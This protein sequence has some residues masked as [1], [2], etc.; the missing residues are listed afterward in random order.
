MSHVF[1]RFLSQFSTDF[2]EILQGLFSRHAATTVK[3]SLKNISKN[4][5]KLDHL[6]CSKFVITTSHYKPIKLVELKFVFSPELHYMP[7]CPTTT[8]QITR[9]ISSI[10]KLCRST[11]SDAGPTLFQPKP[12]KLSPT[13]IIVHTFFLNI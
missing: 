5:S 10:V 8:T 4:S 1:R 3:F 13:N 6:T 7:H 2:D 9:Y 11:V 12:F